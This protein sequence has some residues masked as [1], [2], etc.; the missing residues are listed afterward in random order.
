MHIIYRFKGY[1]NKSAGVANVLAFLQFITET[2]ATT[3]LENTILGPC[4]ATQ[5]NRSP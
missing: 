5:A 3:V 4:T 2:F 1:S